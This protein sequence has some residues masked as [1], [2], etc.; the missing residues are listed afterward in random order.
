MREVKN[1][2]SLADKY[3]SV[4]QEWHPTLNVSITTNDVP[5]K[6]N[7]KYWF[8]CE[9][10]HEW[11]AYVCNRT[12]IFRGISSNVGTGCPYCHNKK[13]CYDNCLETRYP[14]IAKEWHP[15]KNGNVYPKDVIAMSHKK[16]WFMCEKSHEWE[17]SLAHRANGRGC[18]YCSNK[19]IC[20]DNCLETCY[21]SISSE[22]HTTK[23]GNFTPR[24]TLPGIRKKFWF[25]C[26]SNHEWEAY[27][28]ARTGPM[29]TG[30]PHCLN[31]TEHTRSF[32]S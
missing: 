15:A 18:P 29:K 31:K 20:I 5:S 10:G 9:K 19:K 1:G 25:M 32:L 16:Y 28:Y 4:A 21:P 8:R 17:S 26:S 24:D 3:P 13:V 7:K 30:C 27:I 6:S 14:D 23:N 22:W 11:E 2:N 12:S